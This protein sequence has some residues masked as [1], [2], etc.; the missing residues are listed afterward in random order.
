M[1]HIIRKYSKPAIVIAVILILI[2]VLVNRYQYKEDL[3]S[4]QNHQLTD[5]QLPMDDIVD[6][7][8]E[9]T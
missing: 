6:E 5:Q 7:L 8:A 9:G 4:I 1:K 2:T 3:K